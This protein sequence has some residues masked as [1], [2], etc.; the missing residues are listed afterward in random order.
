MRHAGPSFFRH[1]HLHRRSFLKITGIASAATVLGVVPAGEV[2]FS[3]ALTKMQRDK[4][5][6]DDV[7]ALMK[8][9]NQRFRL[10]RRPRTITSPSRRQVP[11]VSIPLQ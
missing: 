2:A 4:L 7:I 8:K 1:N 10:G 3:A 6:P 9:G 5:T 11:R